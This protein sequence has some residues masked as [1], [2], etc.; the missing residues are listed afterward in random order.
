MPAS[1]QM[2]Y[3]RQL[4]RGH[5]GKDGTKK[6]ARDFLYWS[7]LASDIDKYVDKC[8]V[9]NSNKSHQQKETLVLHKTP[10]RPWSIVASDLFT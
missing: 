3:V 1:V 6:R 2:D 9:C 5:C 7:T 4:H 10:Q 8:S